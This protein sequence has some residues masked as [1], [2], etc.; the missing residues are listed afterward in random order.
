MSAQD[1]EPDGGLAAI[2]HADAT[3]AELP[4]SGSAGQPELLDRLL[5]MADA[6]RADHALQHAIE[7]YFALVERH[8]DAPQAVRARE[9]L[10]AIAD[11]EDAAGRRHQA[12]AIYE[13]LL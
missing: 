2:V 8:G 11:R 10:V 5:E 1:P 3:R 12:R 13:R 4:R 7:L 9:R 6:Y